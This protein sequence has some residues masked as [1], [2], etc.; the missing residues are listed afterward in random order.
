MQIY[1]EIK[2]DMYGDPNI[3][4][5]LPLTDKISKEKVNDNAA[6]ILEV[7]TITASGLKKHLEG[8]EELIPVDPAEPCCEH[9]SKWATEMG[10]ANM[11]KDAKLCPYCGKAITPERAAKFD[12]R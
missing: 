1:I 11:A 3:S 7:I 8:C 6:K 5:K 4:T 9:F 2:G 12:L 10:H